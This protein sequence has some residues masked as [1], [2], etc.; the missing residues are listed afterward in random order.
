MGQLDGARTAF[1][2]LRW[3]WYE[4]NQPRRAD[5]AKHVITDSEL[6]AVS[7]A[8][9]PSLPYGYR[10]VPGAVFDPIVLAKH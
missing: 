5:A 3:Q 10:Y 6:R 2:R 1:Q 4:Q 9:F 7:M 8:E